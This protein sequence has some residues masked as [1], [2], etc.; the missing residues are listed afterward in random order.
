MITLLS[1]MQSFSHP[2]E[3]FNAI[4]LRRAVIDTNGL[5]ATGQDETC[6]IPLCNSS[7]FLIG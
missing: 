7:S 4:N 6:A 3:K 2:D 1:A 5:P